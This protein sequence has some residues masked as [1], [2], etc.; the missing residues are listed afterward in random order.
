MRMRLGDPVVPIN[1]PIAETWALLSI[2]DRL[3]LIDGLLAAS[4]KV[5]GLTV[6]TR[7]LAD[8]ARTGVALLDPFS[9]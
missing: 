8:F 1:E 3:P 9:A 6:V 2:P 5:R 7:N 4:A